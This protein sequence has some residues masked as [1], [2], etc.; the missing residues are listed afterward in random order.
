MRHW[1]ARAKCQ[2]ELEALSLPRFRVPGLT[3]TIVLLARVL[4]GF[5]PSM[6]PLFRPLI[7]RVYASSRN[8][9]VD[10]TGGGG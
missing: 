10:M 3:A 2:S 6:S 8:I 9:C 7:M 1:G 4:P 5:R